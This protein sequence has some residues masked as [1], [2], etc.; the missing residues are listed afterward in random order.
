MLHDFVAKFMRSNMCFAAMNC[1]RNKTKHTYICILYEIL[2][3][4]AKYGYELAE[5]KKRH[6][7][8]EPLNEML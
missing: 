4:K 3:Q 5:I 2:K 7:I 1:Y 6:K 8:L